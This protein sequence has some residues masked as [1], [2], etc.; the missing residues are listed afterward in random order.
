MVCKAIQY[1]THC[2]EKQ[3]EFVWVRL[4]FCLVCVCV[5][6]SLRACL[7]ACFTSFIW[8]IL[9]HPETVN[10]VDIITAVS[11]TCQL[12]GPRLLHHTLRMIGHQCLI[13][14]PIRDSTARLSADNASTSNQLPTRCVVSANWRHSSSCLPFC[15]KP[16]II[17]WYNF[18]TEYQSPFC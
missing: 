2:A 17:S 13:S 16:L 8:T 10:T 4:E 12:I 1:C 18:P 15:S 11:Y 3:A 5:C 7:C 14:Q 9:V 6:E